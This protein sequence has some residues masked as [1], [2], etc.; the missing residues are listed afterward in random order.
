MR[1]AARRLRRDRARADWF[2]WLTCAGNSPLEA[3][4]ATIE[5]YKREPLLDGKAPAPSTMAQRLA[6]LSHFYRRPVRR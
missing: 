3:T 6:C 2:V 4:L 1:P 5:S